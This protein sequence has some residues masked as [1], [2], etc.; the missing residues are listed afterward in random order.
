M[1]RRVGSAAGRR[2][3]VLPVPIGLMKA[4]A[5]ALDRLAFFPVT[6]DQLTMLA[7]GNTAPPGPL[8]DLIGRRARE[9]SP[10]NLSY[11][12]PRGSRATPAA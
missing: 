6:R 9:F 10:R 11:L 12:V 4:A 8:E 2:K 5:A 3:L 7:E 1:L